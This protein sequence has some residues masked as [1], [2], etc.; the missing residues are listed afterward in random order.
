MVVRGLTRLAILALP[1]LIARVT[2]SVHPDKGSV[3]FLAKQFAH[4]YPNYIANRSEALRFRTRVDHFDV[5]NRATFE[6]DYLSNDEYYL[7]GRPIFIVVGSNSMVNGYFIE[8]GLFHDI[9]RGERAWLFANEH[10]Y[11]GRSAPVENY[12][13]ANMRFL[14]VEQALMDLIEWIDHLRTEVV[15][16]PKAKV[17]LHGI[18]YGG[19]LAIWARQRFPSLIDGAWG[20]TP[21]VIARVNFPEYGEDLG[22]TIRRLADDECFGT[23]W[24]GFRTA[25]NLIDAG[26]YGRVSEMFRTCEPLAA[27]D[28]LTVETFFYGLKTSIEQEMFG[29]ANP[30]SVVRMCQELASDSAETDLEVLANFFARR[31]APFDCI[32]LDFESNIA[33]AM[34]EEVGVPVNAELGIRQRLYQVCTEFGWFLTSS[35]SSNSPFGTRI[36][37]RYF[38]DTCRAVFG[39]WIDQEVVYDGVRLTNLHFGADDPRVTNALY[40]NAELDPNRLVSITSYRNQNA[41]AFVVHGE[42]AS[43]DWQSQSDADSDDLRRIKDEIKEYVFSWL[44]AKRVQLPPM[45]P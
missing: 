45:A 42:L 12:S 31:Y 8:N 20:S 3:T 11:Y 27:D 13:T 43:M 38:I 44:R 10:R 30:Q 4:P 26:L 37:Y 6:F 24:R 21:P 16:D 34:Y 28:P 41:N 33:S 15:R 36:T 14:S 39:D 2:S 32:A 18:G 25:E 9:A 35:T 7:P 1:C 29:E 22:N 40:V 5:Q 17:I 23:I 19:A